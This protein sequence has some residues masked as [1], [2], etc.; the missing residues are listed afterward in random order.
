VFY[1]VEI[2]KESERKKKKEKLK[3]QQ[4]IF[5]DFQSRASLISPPPEIHSGDNSMIKSLFTKAVI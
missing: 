4:R 3:R 1:V 5:F 2:K